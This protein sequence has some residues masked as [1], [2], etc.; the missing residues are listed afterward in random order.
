MVN[1]ILNLNFKKMNFEELPFVAKLNILSYLDLN[2]LLKFR[3]LNSNCKEISENVRIKDLCIFKEYWSSYV[4][5]FV[6]MN[7]FKI[8]D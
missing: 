1:L 7:H 8:L 5:L 2:S 3:L 6:S 4:S